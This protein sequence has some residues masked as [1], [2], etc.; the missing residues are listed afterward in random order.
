MSENK[1]NMSR[2]S[3]KK[4]DQKNRSKSSKKKTKGSKF[5]FKKVLILIFAFLAAIFIGGAGLFAY[6]VSSTPELSE[7]DITGSISSE[8]LDDKD[9]VIYTLGG[10][11]RE[12][13]TEDQVPQVLKDAIV[14]IEDQRFYKHKGIDPIRIAGAAL[15]NVTGGFAS[16]GGSTITQQLIKLSVFSTN[17]SDQTLKQLAIITTVK[18]LAN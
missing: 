11:K 8:I 3:K 1:E 12:I 16:Q 2:V 10:Q 9:E 13:A 17:E 4:T 7:D 15:A 6:Y 5:T 18:R 14:S